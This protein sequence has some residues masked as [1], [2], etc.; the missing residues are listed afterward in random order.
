MGDLGERKAGEDPKLAAQAPA[1]S[2]QQFLAS[3]DLKPR[4]VEAFLDSQSNFADMGQELFGSGQK[5]AKFIELIGKVIWEQNN[6]AA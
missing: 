3:Q 1:N 4:V 6:K 2:E 5:L